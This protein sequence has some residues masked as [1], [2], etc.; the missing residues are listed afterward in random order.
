MK[1]EKSQFVYIFRA[2]LDV[3]IAPRKRFSY[4]DIA[5]LSTQTLSTLAKAIVSSFDFDFDH[6]YG[7]YNNL[8]DTYQSTE[9][10]ELFTDMGED[11]TPGALGVEHI[12]V[13]QAFPEVNKK[14]RFLFDY[15]DNWLFTIE[16]IDIQSVKNKTKY[17]QTIESFGDAPEQYPDYNKEE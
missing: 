12:K 6:C 16:L 9:I 2:T 13:M 8:Q 15:G 5:I 10:Y 7:F 4:R 14:L 11:P 17:P 1:K 3:R